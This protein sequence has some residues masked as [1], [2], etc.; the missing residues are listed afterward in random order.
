[1]DKYYPI[2]LDLCGKKCVVIGGGKVAQRKVLSLLKCGAKVKVISPK[3]TNKLKELQIEGKIELIKR[4]YIFGDI[5]GSF[6]AFIATDQ[7]KVNKASLEEAKVQGVLVN[8]ID[9]PY[10]CDFVVPSVIRR[11]DLQ[12]TISTNGKSPMLSKKIR[13][14]LEETFGEEYREYISIL[15]DLRELVLREIDD[16]RIRRKVFETV[17]YSDL[18]EKYKNREIKDIRKAIMELYE[19]YR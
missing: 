19:N 4:P 8:V 3:C 1:M 14:E 5:K 15:G 7:E 11:G 9:N 13:Q 18:L 10:E 17:V 12:I 2:M 16:I 6:L